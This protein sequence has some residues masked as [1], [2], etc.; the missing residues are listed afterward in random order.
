M[1]A[2]FSGVCTPVTRPSGLLCVCGGAV[3]VF[4]EWSQESSILFFVLRSWSLLSTHVTSQS[5]PGSLRDELPTRTACGGRVKSV[6]EARALS[7]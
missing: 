7:H 3:C 6:G 4:I 2:A 1:F 5:S